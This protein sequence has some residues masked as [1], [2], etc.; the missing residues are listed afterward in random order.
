MQLLPKT[1]FL[2]SLNRS[3]FPFFLPDPRNSQCQLHI[4]KHRLMWNQII[5]L[6]YKTNCMIP[7]G[8]PV[9][10]FIF[11]RRNPVDDQ[12]T[13]IVPIQSTDD[14]KKRRLSRTTRSQD[15]NKFIVPEIQAYII[16]CLLYQRTC[17]VFFTDMLNLKHKNSPFKL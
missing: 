4:G 13:T 12:I 7:I 2:Q 8:I 5:T 3:L 6:K 11:F 17:T 1:N 10:V 9:S 16:Q 14:V 15:R